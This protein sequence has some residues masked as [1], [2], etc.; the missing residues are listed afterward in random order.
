MFLRQLLRNFFTAGLSESQFNGL[1][2]LVYRLIYENAPTHLRKEETQQRV[3]IARVIGNI[4]YKPPSMDRGVVEE[5]A[6]HAFWRVEARLKRL[7]KS[8]DLSKMANWTPEMILARVCEAEP[9]PVWLSAVGL[10]PYESRPPHLTID[11]AMIDAGRNGLADQLATK[12]EA[13]FRKARL[14]R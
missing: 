8:G 7:R 9:L 10:P 2:S 12:E 3:R 14:A 5:A 1:R 4:G 11:K 6:K 13:A